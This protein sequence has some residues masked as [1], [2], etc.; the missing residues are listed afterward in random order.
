MRAR[1]VGVKS[2]RSIGRED[3]VLEC[4]TG[5]GHSGSAANTA[6]SRTTYALAIVTRPGPR[7]AGVFAFILALII[8]CNESSSRKIS[9]A[10]WS[11][12]LY[13]P[14][15]AGAPPRDAGRTNS[16][17]RNRCAASRRPS[18]CGSALGDLS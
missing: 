12:L 18:C 8:D 15:V 5:R 2:I 6:R 16:T 14:G 13:I 9:E 10:P 11:Q 4:L 7:D 1:T 3:A 17:E